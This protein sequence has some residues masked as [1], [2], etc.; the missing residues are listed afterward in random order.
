MSFIKKKSGPDPLKDAS[1]NTSAQRDFALT[2]I[3]NAFN[4]TMGN[5]NTALNRFNPKATQALFDKGL[6]RYQNF[7]QEAK[8]AED[9]AYNANYQPVLNEVKANLGNQFAGMG[10]A[11]RNNSRGQF[12]Q[13]VLGQNLA[14]NAGKT[15]MGVRQD[16]RNNLLQ[17]NQ[18]LFNPAMDINQQL[19]G[20][21]TNKANAY[22]NFGQTKAN[23][24]L[25]FVSPA[26]SLASQQGQT[27]AA[28]KASQKSGAG[29]MIGGG[30]NLAGSM[31][32]GKGGKK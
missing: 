20:I 15:L 17:E 30:M 22:T 24:R 9:N 19:T 3:D 32:G 16:A 13:A 6:A 2:D 5:L 8:I 1:A 11:G 26:N 27:A 31:F 14:D 29:S 10:E 7:D 21:D 28:Q 25:G 12:A 23:T 4:G 18:A